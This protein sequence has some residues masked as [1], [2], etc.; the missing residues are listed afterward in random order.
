LAAKRAGMQEI[1]LCVDNQKDV[2]EIEERYLNGLTF[3][4]VRSMEEVL[5][6]AL[7]TEQVKTPL[8]LVE[9]Q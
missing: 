6:L 9:N 4:F 3:H 5:Q 1:I 2:N 8:V 7:L